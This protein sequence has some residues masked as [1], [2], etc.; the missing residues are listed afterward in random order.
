MSVGAGI[1]LLFLVAFVAANLPWLTERVFFVLRPPAHGKR[2]W[3]RLLEW[4]VLYVLVGLIGRGLEYQLTGQI[5]P[6]DW[7]FYVTTLCL[8]VVFA[9]PGFIYRH[10]LRRH[11]R[12]RR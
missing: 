9:L 8:F 1:L 11:L 6:Q 12:K 2:E 10:D 7:E 5:Q 3:I 4:A